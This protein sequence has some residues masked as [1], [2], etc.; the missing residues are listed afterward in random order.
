MRFK[1]QRIKTII[2]IAIISLTAFCAGLYVGVLLARHSGS[3]QLIGKN[4]SLADST[5]FAP[6]QLENPDSQWIK[7]RKHG[8]DSIII[9]RTEMND[10]ADYLRFCFSPSESTIFVGR[11]IERGDSSVVVS[12]VDRNTILTLIDSLFISRT[13]PIYEKKIDVRVSGQWSPV[14]ISLEIYEGGK[15]KMRYLP[16]EPIQNK[17]GYIYSQSYYNLMGT[18]NHIAG[19]I[20][21]SKELNDTP[22]DF[23][24]PKAALLKAAEDV[25][26]PKKLPADIYQLIEQ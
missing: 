13:I 11:T 21:R 19:N 24:S 10:S 2:L 23:G 15:C 12:P 26:S 9:S 14:L 8:V 3:S 4:K 22:R 7:L 17:Y 6:R 1:T 20:S 25:Y 18:I 16:I 5:F